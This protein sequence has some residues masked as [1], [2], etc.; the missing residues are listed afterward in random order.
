MGYVGSRETSWRTSSFS[1][2]AAQECVEVASL[3]VAI[4][5]RDSKEAGRG[6]LAISRAAWA[7]LTD[8][9]KR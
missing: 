5:A 1:G 6:H 7:A 4:G 3:G 8:A 9:L 2:Q